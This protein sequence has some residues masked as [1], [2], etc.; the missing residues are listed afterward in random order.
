[1]SGGSYDYLYCKELE[2]LL[3]EQENLARMRDR[4]I[5]L[6]FDKLAAA[7]DNVIASLTSL[8]K[9]MDD[10][11]GSWEPL[12]EAWRAVEWLDSCD[13]ELGTTEGILNKVQDSIVETDFLTDFSKGKI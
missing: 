12:V 3:Q 7:T 6:G 5:E 10:L 9:T 11:E 8:Q 1:M 13:N 4:L 2:E